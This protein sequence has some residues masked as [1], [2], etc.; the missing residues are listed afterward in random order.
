MLREHMTR[1]EFRTPWNRNGGWCDVKIYDH[2]GKTIVIVTEPILPDG[3]Y[4]NKGVS[5]T[6][7]IEY[8]AG[9]LTKYGVKWDKLIEYY[10]DRGSNRRQMQ[11]KDD[12]SKYTLCEVS[13]GAAT[14]SFRG[15]ALYSTPVWMFIEKPD[16][17][18]L[19]GADFPHWFED[20]KY[21]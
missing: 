18:P 21:D 1:L 7:G 4:A 17:E 12:Y 9:E 14:V 15:V 2:E 5:V 11:Y 6:N 19:L 13:L 16:I 3:D 8:I 20:E 10:P